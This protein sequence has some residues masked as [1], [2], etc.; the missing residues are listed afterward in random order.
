[1]QSSVTLYNISNY[2]FNTK[3]A[4]SDLEHTV[5][6]KQIDQLYQYYALKGTR[7]TVEAI[8]MVHEHNHPNLLMLQN[9]SGQFF[10]PHGPLNV[11]EDE[12]TGLVRILNSLLGSSPTQDWDIG[13]ITSVLYRPN[14]ETFWVFLV[15]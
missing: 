14:F 10:L 8:L 15:I 5:P 13:E 4:S 12:T 3:E 2:T 7:T 11:G 1:M 6:S 9:A